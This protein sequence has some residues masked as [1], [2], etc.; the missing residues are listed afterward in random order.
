VRQDFAAPNNQIRNEKMKI[1]TSRFL[2]LNTA[3]AAMFFLHASL[4][5]VFATDCVPAPSGLV[6]WWPGDGNANDIQDG[7]NGNLGS[8]TFVPG[9]VGQAFHFDGT[10]WVTTTNESNL[11]FERTNTFSIDAWIRTTT[12]S[13]NMF[14]VAKR[15][16]VAPYKG[17]AVV[18]DNGQLP[19][20]YST[21][22]TPSGAGWLQFFV[23]GSDTADCPRD[24]AV[25]VYGAT[26][27]NDGQWHHVAATYDGSST[28][29]GVALYVDGVVQTNLVIADTLG[30]NSLVN[31]EGFDIGAGSGNGPQPFNGDIDEIDV[32]NRVISQAEVQG[33][34]NAGTAGKC[35]LMISETQLSGT[36]FTFNFPTVSNQSYTVQQNTNLATTNCQFLETITGD[37]SLQQF[38][39]PTTNGQRF[40]RLSRP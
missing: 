18:I 10:S 19:K 9:E 39:V 24:H 31:T 7:N 27:V 2:V 6:S 1:K 35:K 34:F 4:F 16:L 3:V 12:T 37:G 17:Y 26:S 23:D 30:T 8:V 40:F 36:N 11:S 32:F 20:C 38:Q 13:E 28:A 33:I 22:P 25:I 15:E 29:A 21:D 14:V 5:T